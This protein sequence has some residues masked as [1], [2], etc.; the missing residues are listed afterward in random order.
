MEARLDLRRALGRHAERSQ[1]G[2]LG[3]IGHLMPSLPVVGE[4]GLDAIV[5]GQAIERSTIVVS[6]LGSP[7]T[8]ASSEQ[9][10]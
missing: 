7:V 3:G 9:A 1:Q 5:R 8:G 6:H 4:F 2:L 10:I